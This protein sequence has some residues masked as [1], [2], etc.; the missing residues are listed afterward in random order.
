MISFVV[1][2]VVAKN[3]QAG[4]KA[5]SAADIADMLGL[6]IILTCK[7]I[8]EF[9]E[10]GLFSQVYSEKEKLNYYQ[11]AKDIKLF[12]IKYV[13]DALGN[14]GSEIPLKK[15]NEFN[16]LKEITELISDSIS[17]SPE[18]KLLTEI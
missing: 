10:A 14:Y 4:N 3:F 13:S 2:Q 9:L 6:P 18:N 15:S 1:A 11:P 8:D 12:T 17:K 5:L 7:I 16:S